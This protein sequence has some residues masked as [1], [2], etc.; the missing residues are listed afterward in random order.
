MTRLL[1]A[2]AASALL[3]LGP[4]AATAAAPQ[5]ITP[6]GV[7][8]VKLGMTWSQLHHQHLV[9]LLHQGHCD[10][11]GP[12][13]SPFA[14]LRSP[15]K[16]VADVT[17]SVPHKL[18]D[19]TIRGGATARGVRVGDSLA[20]VKAKFPNRTV[21]HDI[22]LIFVHIPNVPHIKEQFILNE[23]TKTVDVIG[24]PFVAICE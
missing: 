4:A 3:A 7:G 18:T 23:D 8:Q 6:A 12:N 1:T 15:L 24:V 21:Q 20:K 9:G 10:A 11:A 13:A 16:G 5:K 22:G 2:A 14:K 19:I 17:K